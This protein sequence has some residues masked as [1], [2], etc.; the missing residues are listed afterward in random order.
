MLDMTRRLNV[1]AALALLLISDYTWM[2]YRAARPLPIWS[3]V[4]LGLIV[5]ISRSASMYVASVNLGIQDPNAEIAVTRIIS[6]GVQGITVYPLAILLVSIIARYTAERR[7]LLT[8]QVRILEREQRDEQQ[9][10][11]TTEEIIAPLSRDLTALGDRLDADQ[12]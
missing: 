1:A 5:G 2:R 6:G 9:W 11:Q 12:I 10:R 3:V 7:R 8:E 4:L